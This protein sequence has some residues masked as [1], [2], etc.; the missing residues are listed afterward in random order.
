[1]NSTQ[2][3]QRIER[4]LETARKEIGYKETGVNITK[5][6]AWADENDIWFTK[7]QG[8]AWC[9]T[10]VMWCIE[11]AFNV[12]YDFDYKDVFCVDDTCCWSDAWMNNFK[13]KGRFHEVPTIGDFAFKNG[14]I[15]VVEWA[16]LIKGTVTV[17]EGNVDDSVKRSTYP[18]SHF[19]GYGYPKWEDI[20]YSLEDDT[21]EAKAKM[22]T[23]NNS[24]FIGKSDGDYHWK[25]N[26]TREEAAIILYRM[27]IKWFK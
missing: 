12:D 20:Y 21:E 1:M 3:A 25:D 10:F 17:I 7:V 4:F 2:M 13:S 23:I 27:W 9:T 19:L 15:A 18:I 6:N 8:L 26:L 5:Y 11:K 24:I 14:H 16:D 22:W